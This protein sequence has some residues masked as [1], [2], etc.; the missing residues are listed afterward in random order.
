MNELLKFIIKY[1]SFLYDDLGAKFIDSSARG[2]DAHLVLEL[3]DLRLR[4]VRDRGQIVL[5]FQRWSHHKKYAWFS[6]GLL[7]KLIADTPFESE[8]MNKAWANFLKENIAEIRTAFSRP[9][10][11]STEKKL[12]E[13]ARAR[14]KYLFG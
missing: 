2:G 9:L 12:R 13:L 3:P 7:K 5:D 1:C 4:F 14:A 10:Y 8:V 11:M 6:L